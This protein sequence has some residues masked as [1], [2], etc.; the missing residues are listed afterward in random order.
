M[1]I[2]CFEQFTGCNWERTAGHCGTLASIMCIFF[3]IMT[4]VFEYNIGIGLYTFLIGIIISIW[5]INFIYKCFGPCMKV[6]QFVQ[7]TLQFKRPIVLTIVYTL[8]SI[9]TFLRATPS[10]GGGIFLLFAA[11]I[12]IF[13]Q[14]NQTSDA[15]D[16]SKSGT[17]ADLMENQA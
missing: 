14:V 7:E 11:L 8:M 15:N 4:W 3:G 9:V 17:N 2:G 12:N 1:A 16:K 10:I 5:E 6:Y 13:A